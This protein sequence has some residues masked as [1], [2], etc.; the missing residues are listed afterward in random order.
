MRQPLLLI[1]GRDLLTQSP[2]ERVKCLQARE[3][4]DDETCWLVGWLI[5]TT[6]RGTD[7]KLARLSGMDGIGTGLAIYAPGGGGFQMEF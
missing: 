7:L 4:G 2:P 3:V 1:P 6:H 5:G